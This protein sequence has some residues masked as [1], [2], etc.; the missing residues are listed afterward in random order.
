MPAQNERRAQTTASF[1]KAGN[2]E[3]IKVKKKRKKVRHS[4]SLSNVSVNTT[5]TKATS[6][7]GCAFGD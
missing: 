4:S 7:C 2:S 6:K 5:F 1:F 3:G